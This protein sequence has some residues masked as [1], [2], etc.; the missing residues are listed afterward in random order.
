MALRPSFSRALANGFFL[1]LAPGRSPP[2][3]SGA[4]HLAKYEYT[5]TQLGNPSGSMRHWQTLLSRY[6]TALKTSH[7]STVRGLVRLRTDSSSGRICS[8]C[9]RLTSLGYGFLLFRVIL[10]DYDTEEPATES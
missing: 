6:K 1:R 3:R 7:K 5:V 2:S 4:L 10:L 9:S 8:N